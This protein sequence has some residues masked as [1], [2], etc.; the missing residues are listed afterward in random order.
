M[1]SPQAHLVLTVIGADRPGLVS[2][3]SGPVERHGGSWQRSQMARLAG[4]FAGIVL[5]TVPEAAVG[6]LEGDLAGLAADGLRVDVRRTDAPSEA[7]PASVR[8]HLLGTDRPGIVAEISR[9]IAAHGVGIEALT[10]D[11]REAPMAGGLLFEVEA[12]L[13]VPGESGLDELR[14]ALEQIADELMVELSLE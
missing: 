11:L 14:A 9:T 6:A 4:E 13:S 7:A 5:V 1:S 12:E 2:A 8:L 3:V 10:T